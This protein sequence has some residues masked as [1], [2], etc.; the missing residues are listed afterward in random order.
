MPV[1]NTQRG[2]ADGAIRSIHAGVGSERVYRQVM[3]VRPKGF[4]GSILKLIDW[5]TSWGV[6]YDL[7]PAQI[8]QNREAEAARQTW[9]ATGTSYAGGANKARMWMTLLGAYFL[10]QPEPMSE[11]NFPSWR[12]PS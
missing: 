5:P 7:S 8:S 11:S 3:A 10:G 2:Q 9:E 1:S 4:R 12:K 6:L